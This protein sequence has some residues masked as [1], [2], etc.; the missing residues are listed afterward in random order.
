MTDSVALEKI[1]YTKLPIHDCFLC[2]ESPEFSSN[3]GNAWSILEFLDCIKGNECAQSIFQRVM[4]DNSLYNEVMNRMVYL[5]NIP[6]DKSQDN[7][8]DVALSVY[9]W[10]LAHAGEQGL[11]IAAQIIDQATNLFWSNILIREWQYYVQH[12]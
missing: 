4:A 5:M 9:W 12:I 1:D 8:Y 6:F 10:I 3:I 11:G 7:P 2:V